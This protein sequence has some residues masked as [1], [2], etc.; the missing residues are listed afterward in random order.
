MLEIPVVKKNERGVAEYGRT[1]RPG[2]YK[3]TPPSGQ[4]LAY[5]VNASRRESD[6]QKLTPK[7]IA[8]FAKTHG[9]SVVHSGAEYRALDHAHRYGLEMWRPLLWLLVAALFFE[10][11]LQQRFARVRVKVR[12]S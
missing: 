12:A 8:D 7:E 2:L 10:I 9:V 3:L 4:S 1:Q 6:L 5:V 11:V